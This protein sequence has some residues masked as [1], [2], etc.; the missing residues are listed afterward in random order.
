[1]VETKVIWVKGMQFAGS[2]DS[3]HQVIMD[4]AP[5]VG[6]DD[7]GVRP[8]ELFLIGLGGCTGMDVVSIL[9]KMRVE[10]EDLEIE[11]KAKKADE[12]PKVYEEIEMRY[13]I[14]GADIP[15]D[16]FLRAIELS[17]QRYCSASAI[18]RKTAEFRTTHEII[19]TYG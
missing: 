14:T 8:M 5:S 18:L 15:E 2:A 10:F 16:K 4:A 19:S 3:K 9:R 11:I 6:G 13:V 1:M 17:Q 7:G 12:H